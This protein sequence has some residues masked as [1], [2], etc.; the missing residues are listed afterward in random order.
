MKALIADDDLA[1]THMLSSRLKAMKFRI[2]TAEDAIQ[3]WVNILRHVPSLVVL[4]LQMPGGTGRAVLRSLKKSLKTRHIPVLA[5]SASEDK[6][7]SEEMLSMGADAFLRKPIDLAVFD[8]EVSRLTGALASPDPTA[9]DP[10]EPLK[11]IKVLIADDDLGTLRI[12]DS[13]LKE[14]DFQVVMAHNGKDALKIL[15]SSDP[16]KMAILDWMMPMYTGPQVCERIRKRTTDNYVYTLLLTS[17]GE[18]SEVV[19]GLSSGADDYMVKPIDANEL[20]VRMSAG[21]RIVELQEELLS[22]AARLR[23][24]LCARPIRENLARGA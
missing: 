22:T 1:L 14:W 12:L 13:L 9:D 18:K 3:A 20:K 16:P 15:E 10:Q 24:A 5:I 19:E 7:V 11:P 17:K 4:D 23:S 6:G 21:R 2:V 8:A